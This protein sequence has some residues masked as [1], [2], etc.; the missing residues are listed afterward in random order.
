LSGLLK[1]SASCNF[2]RMK[3]LRLTLLQVKLHWENPVANR[4]MFDKHFTRI[5]P[6]TT[7]LIVLPEMFTT[8][9]SMNAR[10]F[11]EDMG[12]HTMKWMANWAGQLDA[13]I[14]GSIIIKENN[15]FYNR[16]IWMT[17]DGTYDFYDKRHLFRM[18]QEQ[19]IYTSG[20]KRLITHVKGWRICP[21]ICYDLRFPVWCRSQNDYDLLL[22]VAN[23]P[24]KRSFAWK[25]LLIARAIENQCYVAGV[26]R[27][28]TDI[29]KVKHSGDSVL[30]NF[31]GESVSDIPAVK[32]KS[33]TSQIS[34]EE[35][36]LFRSDFPAHEDS[37]PFSLIH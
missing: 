7:D 22:F 16:L 26:N 19:M 10:S 24:A 6:G 20:K 14:T 32:I 15:C 5:K 21:M 17:P 35:L 30:I 29:H 36:Q 18:G 8:G 27:V 11:F 37:D 31:L 28:G 12:G 4:E 1:N 9:F 33:E 23:W 34:L 3:D 13:V 25:Q 2:A